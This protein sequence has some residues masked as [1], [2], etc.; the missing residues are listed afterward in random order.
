MGAPPQ[1]EAHSLTN[2]FSF[3]KMPLHSPAMEQRDQHGHQE[4]TAT[5]SI[6]RYFSGQKASN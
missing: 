1:T 6:S 4:Q 2:S 5:F 3:D